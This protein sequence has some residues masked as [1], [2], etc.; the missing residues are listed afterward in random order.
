MKL[1]VRL[2]LF[3]SLFALPGFLTPAYPQEPPPAKVVT[4]TITREL[5]A[6][7]QSYIGLLK[8]DRTSRVSSEVAGLVKQVLVNEGDRIKAGEVLVR[9]DTELLDREIALVKTRIRQARLRMELAE[10]NLARMETLL[11]KMGTSEKNYDDAL[12]AFQDAEIEKESLEIELE[13]LLIQKRKSEITAPFDGT[14]LEK[15]TEQGNWVQQGSELVALGSLH[16]I[17]I[18]VP[19]EESI[20]QYITP[21]QEVPLQLKAF[22]REMTGTISAIDPVADVRTKNIFIEIGIP[23]FMGMIENMSATVYIPTSEQRELSIIPRDALVKFQGKD[24][25]YTIKDGKAALLPVNI[26]TYLGQTVAA[27]NPYFE[28]GMAVIT[29]G[30]ERLRPDQPVTAEG[31]N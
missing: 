1:F 18:R 14:L 16:D 7:N 15:N 6:D 19:V 8:Y 29:E 5:V 28:E 25:V 26:V 12:Y 23:A 27:D 4:R 21:G 3:F 11:E 17:I 10:K 24:F 2:F 9:L 22:N 30:N 31:G 13:K 20:L